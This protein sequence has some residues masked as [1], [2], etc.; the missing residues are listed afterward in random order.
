MNENMCYI[1]VRYLVLTFLSN[2]VFSFPVYLCKIN[3]LQDVLVSGF[4]KIL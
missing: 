3:D 2:M 1:I 4:A